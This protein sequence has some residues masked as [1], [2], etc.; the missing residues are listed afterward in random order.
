MEEEDKIIIE[1][2]FE[3]RPL[4]KKLCIFE[5]LVLVMKSFGIF[6]KVPKSKKHLNYN[7]LDLKSKRILNRIS[8]HLAVMKLEFDDFF[9]D[10]VNTQV[11]R[12][13]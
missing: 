3:H 13:K 10:I 6:E 4:K 12:T 7:N 2:I 11:V 1:Y 5:D 8:N 9:K